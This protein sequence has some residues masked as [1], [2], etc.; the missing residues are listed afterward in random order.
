MT[1]GEPMTFNTIRRIG[2][3]LI[4]PAASTAALLPTIHGDLVDAL[5]YYLEL[6][7][8]RRGCDSPLTGMTVSDMLGHVLPLASFA[9][10]LA[11]G[12]STS[13]A[14]DDAQTVEV[15]ISAGWAAYMIP[16]LL[17]QLCVTIEEFVNDLSRVSGC[18]VAGVIEVNL[19]NLCALAYAL[20]SLAEIEADEEASAIDTFRGNLD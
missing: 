18:Q 15:T 3:T 19:S 7:N 2:D 9:H 14:D 8:T 4:I 13:Q 12:Q 5:R 17:D 11:G 6:L 16:G 10:A 1:F 20:K